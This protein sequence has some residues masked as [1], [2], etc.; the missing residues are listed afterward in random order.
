[1]GAEL[2][3]I[4]ERLFT[5]VMAPLV[6]G[7]A[8]R[9]GPAIGARAA[10]ALGDGRAPAD[11]ELA[12][13]VEVG[14]VRRARRLAPVDT[15]PGPTAAEWALAAAFNDL[16]QSASPA[17]DSTLRRRAAARILACAGETLD[18]IAPPASVGEALARH[19][20]F[21]RA[22][23][24]T[25]SDTR[26]TWWAGDRT[27][28]GVDPPLRLQ[29]WARLRRVS[30]SRMP[31][32]LLDVYPLAVEREHLEDVV[33]RFLA[34]SPLTDLATSTREA[35]AFEWNGSL[36]ALVG[37]RG[38]RTLAHRALDRLD[39]AQVDV[40]LERATRTLLES[41]A[42]SLATPAVELVAERARRLEVLS[43][44]DSRPGRLRA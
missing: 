9:P 36:L 44:E 39:A 1:V 12:T 42:R 27:F 38:G 37:A 31:V 21:A 2:G 34:R 35:P 40:V 28:R 16:V 7:G 22:L 3:A 15:V 8:M 19:S 25:R 33:R 26:V 24:V 20:W 14:R 30:V 23:D 32:R 17:F 5:R 6:L 10:L 11:R 41:E 43:R 4:A 29:R 13:L 18:R